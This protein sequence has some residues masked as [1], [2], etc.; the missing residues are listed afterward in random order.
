M[1]IVPLA[2][3]GRCAKIV[4][5]LGP[6]SSDRSTIKALFDA[7]AD[8]FRLNFSHGSHADHKAR[9]ELIRS[10]EQEVGR[11]IAVLL[12]LQGPKL[13]IGRFAEGPVHV[14]E[15]ERFRLDLQDVPGNGMGASLPHPE[16]FAALQPGTDLLV[17]DG[18]VRLKVIDCGLDFATTEVVVGGML[19]DRKGV[20]VPSVLLPI[21]A[22]TAKDKD[23]L[24][25][26]LRL[27][28][29][30]VALS[31]VQRP[32]DLEEVQALV[33]GQAGVLAKLEKPAAIEALDA[34]VAKADAIMVARGDL[35]VE[36]PAEQVPP[37]QKRIIRSCRAAGKPVIVAT[38][39]LESMT[40]SSVPTRAEASDVAT[41]VYD[42]AD[43][44]MLSAESASGKFPREAVAVMDRIIRE[45]ESDPHYRTALD[46][47]HK[48]AQGSAADAVCA[49]M[50]LAAS[51]MPVATIVTYTR[52]G[53]TSLRAARE[54]PAVRVICMTPELSTARRL[55]VG[56]GVHCV[57]APQHIEDVPDMVS[58]ACSLARDQGFAKGGDSVLVAAGMPFGTAGTTNFLHIAKA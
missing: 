50:R 24:E 39:M 31:F 56:W 13:R 19:S 30:W 55:A 4:A 36:L 18:K 6:A 3:R 43:A 38:Q 21:S 37:I 2:T 29:D 45:V 26:G 34:I 27:G 17:D 49:S 23:D 41:A 25:F 44:V 14:S 53:Y 57:H 48:P 15:G 33:R 28:V 35:G 42:G 12:D 7:G 8:V 9:Y 46:A 16:I 52:S 51:L 10:I 20:N 11:P 22:L 5:T 47:S 54:R 32:E 1:S 58:R 40:S